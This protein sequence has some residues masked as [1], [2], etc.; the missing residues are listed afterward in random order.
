MNLILVRSWLFMLFLS[1]GLFA[2]NHDYRIKRYSLDDGMSQVSVNDIVVDDLGFV[3]LGTADGLNRFDG[4]NFKIYKNKVSDSTSV[5]GNFINKLTKDLNGR[6]WIG[7]KGNGLSYYDAKTDNFIKI[8]LSQGVYNETITGIEP[9]SN[10]GLWVATRNKGVYYLTFHE[11][12]NTFHAKYRYKI[13]DVTCL[14]IDEE[15]TLWLGDLKGQLFGFE[16][17]HHRPSV[18]LSV[19]GN[20]QAIYRKNNLLLIG[21]YEG[22]YIYNT[23]TKSIKEYELEVSGDFKT[24]HVVDFLTNEHGYIWIATD[25]GLYLF[26][27][28]TYN[29]LRKYDYIVDSKKGLS[30]N[31]VRSMLHLDANKLLVGTASGLNVL[32]FKAPYI[33]NISKSKKGK[34]LLN[35]DIIFSIY[36]NEDHLWVGTSDGGLNLITSKKVY[37]FKDNQN[38]SNAIAGSVVR[39]I[40]HDKAHERMWFGTT[41]GL[42]MIDLKSFNPEKPKFKNFYFEHNNSNSI[43]MNFIM[44]LA[45]DHNSNLWGVTYEQGIFRMEYTSNDVYKIYRYYNNPQ[46]ENSLVNNAG[47]CIRVDKMNNIW[48]GTQEGVSRLSFNKKPYA[49]PQFTNVIKL[50]SV[51]NTLPHNSVNDILIDKNEHVWLGTREGLGLL[52]KDFTVKSWKK[53][54]QFPNDLIYIVQDDDYGN[55]WLGTNNGMSKFN[56]TTYTFSH[57][58]VSDNIQGREFDLHAK[59]KDEDG[60]LYLGGIDGI[61]YFNPQDIDKI[62]QPKPLYFSG[63][64]VKSQNMSKALAEDPN[65]VVFNYNQFPF[66]LSYSTIDFQ[67]DK[68]IQYAYKLLPQNKEWN[69]LASKEIP[70][71]NLA[72]GKYKLQ[73][74]GFSR[75]QEW[76]KPPLELNIIIKPPWWSTSI[77]YIIYVL[78]ILFSA[79]WFYHFT[80]SRKLALA[81]SKR[82]QE[83]D[84]LKNSLYTNITHEF[85][86]PLTVILGLI[87]HLK[88]DA[89]KK[90]VHSMLNALNVMQR[91]GK[92]LL[93][94]VNDML[95]LTKLESSRMELNYVQA[96]IVLYLKYLFESFSS[97]AN[98]KQIKYIFYS[99]REVFFMDFDREKVDAIVTNLLMNAI[100]FT[101]VKGEVTMQ[102]SIVNSSSGK[103]FHIK[104][105]DTGIGL[106]SDE[107]PLVFEKFYQ[108]DD[109]IS[110]G[111][112]GTGIGLALVKELVLL[113][114]GE[115]Y[116]TSE[117]NKGSEFSVLLPVKN[118]AEFAPEHRL[119]LEVDIHNSDQ[120]AHGAMELT[121]DIEQ[122]IALIIE[123]NLDVVYYLK[124][125]LNNDYT[126]YHAPNGEEGIAMALKYVPDIIVCDVMMPKKDGF[127][128]CKALKSNPITDHI[129]IILL[130]AKALDKDRIQGL[131]CGADAYLI[132]PFNKKELTVRLRQLVA[133]RNRMIDKFSRKDFVKTYRNTE[134]KTETIF[135][136]K[137][138]NLI[139]ENIDDCTFNSAALA[140]SMSLSESQLYRKLKAITDKSTALFIRSIRLQKAKELIQT[141]DRTISEVAY[142]VGFTDPSWFSRAFKEEFGDPPSTY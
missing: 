58:A 57:Y 5:S 50:D 87:D 31:T 42:S 123:D 81:E 47:Q 36:K 130:T 97:L 44:D 138:I 132:K 30:N 110:R 56:T 16:N 139:H 74:N 52:K 75:G 15:N 23:T 91:N 18:T 104:I 134:A 133:T 4:N 119:T 141:T 12:D 102:L 24:K 72:P 105:I 125:C 121:S 26:N 29:V 108:V 67:F 64:R 69:F 84:G 90:G 114:E 39:A 25:R 9:D 117:I 71:I 126:I 70:F 115:V 51:S 106:S 122:D 28:D 66:S 68:N 32:N 37:Y 142:S 20:V 65:T 111:Y 109:S 11:G 19:A 45:L 112:Q 120:E 124:T 94:L 103:Y 17:F 22:F 54:S 118:V 14:F 96:D 40:V 78:I 6:I 77:A 55:L 83:I 3:W 127:E 41:R 88:S 129:P 95:D 38:K 137:V 63:L 7:T 136:D 59:F 61:T 62:D 76:L 82:L 27:A 2:Q 34:H 140:S 86:T 135:I 21:S 33:K 1:S 92:N 85:R 79:Y 107:I 43:N 101:A 60:N 53:Q 131:K 13:K 93:K 73:L 35:D 128:V 98:E 46:N 89:S 113:M 116:V 8:K 48:I 10:G 49:L 80:I 100:K 99:K